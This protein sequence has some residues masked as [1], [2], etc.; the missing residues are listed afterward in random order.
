MG[1]DPKIGGKLIAEI[2]AAELTIR[3]LEIGISMKRP[4]GQTAEQVL[5]QVRRWT[6]DDALKA[7]IIADFERMSL[8]A[9]EY[10]GECC[11]NLRAIQ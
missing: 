7:S 10:F 1:A 9:I 8:A 6:T 5:A 3:L 4:R 2:D 11:A